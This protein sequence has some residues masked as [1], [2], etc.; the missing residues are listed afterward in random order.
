MLLAGVSAPV[1]ATAALIGFLI[2]ALTSRIPGVL[3]PTFL[4]RSLT[5]QGTSASP[6]VAL[7]NAWARKK[8][9]AQGQSGYFQTN[10]TQYTCSV[11]RARRRRNHPMRPTSDRR[12]SQTR[13]LQRASRTILHPVQEIQGRVQSRRSGQKRGSITDKGADRP[14]SRL[15]GGAR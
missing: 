8:T 10:R 5:P 15:E 1:F 4:I 13:S 7:K 9:K 2:E 14:H 12:V 3:Y 6:D 11:P